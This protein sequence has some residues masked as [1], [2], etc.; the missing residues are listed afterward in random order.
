MNTALYTISS[1]HGV[2]FRP[3]LTRDLESLAKLRFPE[4]IVQ[5]Y[6]QHEPEKPVEGEVIIWPINRVIEEN[7]NLNPGSITAPFGYFVFATTRCGDT[8]CFDTNSS[9]VGGNPRIV[10][11]SHEVLPEDATREEVAKMAK[12]IA[13]NLEEFL[14][15][16]SRGE[17]DQ[18]CLY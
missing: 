7:T 4:S 16:F 1:Q 15:Q 8:Y 12:P 17:V 9:D 11:I 3:A 2:T 13:Q 14:L 10:L 5:F 18:E 6:A